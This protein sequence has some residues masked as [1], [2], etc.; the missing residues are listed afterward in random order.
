MEVDDASEPASEGGAGDSISSATSF[1][2]RFRIIWLD[3]AAACNLAIASL[4]VEG[5]AWGRF[6]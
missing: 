6:R 4:V 2:F 5:S 1:R 3:T